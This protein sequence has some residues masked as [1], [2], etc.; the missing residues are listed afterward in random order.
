MIVTKKAPLKRC[1]DVMELTYGGRLSAAPHNHGKHSVRARRTRTVHAFWMVLE[2]SPPALPLT[3]FL[4]DGTEALALF[5][6]EEEAR[7]FCHFCEEGASSNL[8]Q[9]TTGEVISLLYCPWCAAKHVA[10][11][12]FPEILGS[13]LLLELLTLSREEFALRFAG[14]D[15]E[16]VARPPWNAPRAPL[17]AAR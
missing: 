17:L 11:D 3:V 13:R 10:L 4:P 7:M 14:L 16:P 8:R 5:S 1:A 2:G 12:P 6:G 15:S 9:T